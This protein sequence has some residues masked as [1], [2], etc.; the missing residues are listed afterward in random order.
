MA[1][2][3]KVAGL[4]SAVVLAAACREG[5]SPEG[6]V[7]NRAAPGMPAFARAAVPLAPGSSPIAL[8]QLNGMLNETGT[9]FRKG[10]NTTNPHNGDAIVVTVFWLGSGPNLVQSVF[11]VMTM[12]SFPRVGNKYTLVEYV[13]SG[14]ISMATYV[15]TNVQGFPDAYN[16]PAQDSILAVEADFSQV[17]SGGLLISA[18]SGVDAV[19]TQV[20]GSHSSGAGSGS[21]PTT[22]DP[23][24][25]AVGAGSLALGV[26]LSNALVGA[27]APL[28]FTTLAVQSN[29]DFGMVD[30]TNYLLSPTVSSVNPQWLWYFT[31]PSTWLASVITLNPAPHL[32]FAV[33]PSRTLP[34][35]TIQPSVQVA[36]VDALGNRVTSFNGQVTIAIGHNGGTVFPG[37]LSGTRTVNAVNGVATFADLSIDQLG[38]GYTLVASVPN[39]F[40]AE[41]SPFNIGA[42]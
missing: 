42:F 25:V 35:M 16:A 14:G 21:A 30:E 26:T 31:Q 13:S 2:W 15:A 3:T 8:D 6:D 33:Q 20:V 39:V 1:K 12:P 24:T 5:V 7:Q 28:N 34:L 11:D 22:A 4:L 19:T 10:F 36:I 18:W 29:S 32:A 9:L 17:V 40:T 38:T 23:G 37:T 27:E 41:S